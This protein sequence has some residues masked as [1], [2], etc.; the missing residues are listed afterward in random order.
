MR[1]FNYRV[2]I[3]QEKRIQDTIQVGAKT[4]L[5]DNVFRSAWNTVQEA[6]V[7]ACDPRCDLIEGDKVFVH[8]FVSEAE[9]KL[10][11]MDVI[12]SWL[13]YSQIYARVRNGELKMINNYIFV[14]PI[15]Y[16][17]LKFFNEDQG[18]LTHSKSGNEY[19]E[20]IGIVRHISDSGKEAGLN[21]GDMV[22]FNKNC[23][24]QIQVGEEKFYRME[25]RD[26][27]TTIDKDT[28]ISAIKA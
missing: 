4:F 25:I 19:V 27:I 21:E 2:I 24:Y 5:L 17:N 16:D 22:L 11:F 8:H 6:I 1:P 12:Q 9:H 20:R 23:E 15:K 26:I 18:F 14:E 13:E 10:P 28:K 3:T 7:V